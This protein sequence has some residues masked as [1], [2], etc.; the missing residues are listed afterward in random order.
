MKAKI[1]SCPIC[2]NSSK[3][4]EYARAIISPWMRILTNSKAKTS[5]LITCSICKGAFFTRR[6]NDEE[7]S[8]IYQNYRDEKYVQLRNKWEPWYSKDFNDAHA[9]ESL[10][11]KRKKALQ[12]FLIST[13]IYNTNIIVDVG[14][15]LGQYIPDLGKHKYVLDL[16]EQKL[17]AGVNRINTIQDIDNIDL[18]IYAHV[19][20]HVSQPLEELRKL[21]SHARFV[22]VEVPA[23]TPKIN[24]LRK[25][26]ILFLF[27]YATSLNPKMWRK[28]SRASGGRN[29]KSTFIRQS[30]HINFFNEETVKQMAI[31][32]GAHMSSFSLA[33]IP[34]PEGG[35]MNVIRAIYSKNSFS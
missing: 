28:F 20:E 31:S 3:Q 25:N 16:S 24:N 13:Q 7:M 17:K 33:K 32:L 19:L 30:E 27:N 8:K 34:S 23:G 5:T 12:K 35:E 26:K 15:D 29:S 1:I 9:D 2:G 10:I 18:I 21:I 14:G 22:Y 6:Y 11:E 4:T